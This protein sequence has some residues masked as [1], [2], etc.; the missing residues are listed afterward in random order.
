M[1]PV[2]AETIRGFSL[3]LYRPIMPRELNLGKP[4]VPRAGNLV[5]VVTG[6]R[7][8]GKTFR[9]FQVMDEL[10]A[11]GVEEG[12]ILYFNFEDERLAPVTPR[13]GDEVLETFYTLHPEALSE[14]AYLF[15]DEIQ[16]MEGWGGW[17]RRIVDTTRATIYVT[18]SSS[19]LLS[20]EISTEFRGRSIEFVLYPLSFRE[21]LRFSRTD[22]DPDSQA[23][24]MAERLM[25]QQRFAAYLREGGFPAVQGLPSAQAVPVLQGY[26][27]RVVARDVIE[28]HDVRVPRV[29]ADFARRVLSMN[30]R[31]LS[32]RKMENAFRSAGH[33]T[34][35]TYLSEILNYFDEAFL[36]RVIGERTRLS[37]PEGNTMVKAYAVDPGLA[38]ANAPASAR[39]DGQSL[40]DAVCIELLRRVE[41]TREGAVSFLKTRTHGYE[42]DFVVGDALFDE[43][44]ALYQVTESLEGEG[45]FER[46]TRALWEAM[47]ELGLDEATIVVGEGSERDIERDGLRI[48]CTPAWRWFLSTR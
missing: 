33:R 47:S 26:A 7:R 2:I 13:T 42:V 27:Q 37:A 45:T 14:G 5:T 10:V 40:E 25:L 22:V 30:G 46:E 41:T 3:E 6:M 17:L 18:G 29:A 31:T 16:E 32:L 12:H 20:T 8:S 28:R 35:R 44:L 9:L 1:N 19:K 39:D 34:S 48:H 24:T 36:V 43:G 21:T 15:F 4:L 11:A 23:F 38:R